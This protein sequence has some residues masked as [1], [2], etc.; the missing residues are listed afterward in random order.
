[1][2]NERWILPDGIDEVLPPEAGI[3]ERK[4]RELLDLYGSWGYD[5]VIPP[6][7]EFLDS[8]L[9][10]TGSDLD[11][12]TFKLTDQLSGRMMGI[13]ADITPQAARID[14]HHIRSQCPTRLCYLGTVLH[15]RSDGFAGTRSPLQIGA[16][17]Y[18]HS[19]VESD[20]E[21]LRLMMET[22]KTTGVENVYLDLGHV[23][24]Y[25]G[26]AEQAGLNKYQERELFAALQRKAMPEVERLL[27]AFSID[28]EHAAMLA[29]LGA[30][31]GDD[32]LQQA[33]ELL[34][35]ASD[36][37]KQALHYLRMVA[38]QIAVWLPQ[39][40]VH[41]DLAELRG[42]HFHTGVVFAAF[43]PGSGKEIAR[44]GRYDAIGSVFG[45]SRPATGFSTDLKTLIRV[46]QQQQIADRSAVFAPWSDDPGLQ[47]EIER[48][49]AAGQRVICALP[50]QHGDAKEMGCDQQLVLA[51][52]Q[53]RLISI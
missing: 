39:I 44:G 46:A 29:H 48:L 45:R 4:R 17:L 38:E 12:N 28:S 40:P 11:L 2:E 14:A 50:G 43:V 26:L 31:N 7:V 37:V 52:G 15:T 24:I 21:V 1:M 20:I 9:T 5:F 22:L 35:D 13:R 10:G 47:Q 36:R 41:F 49:R 19:G 53:W 25:K 16:E 3:I 18:G 27:D 23:G 32:A 51:D 33:T 30:L 6:F 42:Y 34:R 8:L